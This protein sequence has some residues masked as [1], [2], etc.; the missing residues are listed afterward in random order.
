VLSRQGLAEAS[1][2]RFRASLS[3]FFAWAV[4][5]RLIVRTPV[6]AT[7]VPRMSTPRAEM[8]PLSEAELELMVARAAERNQRLADVLLVDAWTRLRWSELGA[9][10]VR[11]FAE[12][13]LPMI[14]VQQAEPEGVRTKG[15]K[16]GKPGGCRSRTGCCRWSAP[17]RP[18]GTG[19]RCCSLP[20]PAPSCTPALSSGP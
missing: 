11:D 6:T 5:E 19:T 8:F 3:A 20:T 7:R 10:R 2:R 18:A 12:V 15:T 17:S 4:R 1:V 16:S 13:P 14:V 9:C